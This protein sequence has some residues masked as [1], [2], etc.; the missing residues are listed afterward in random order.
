MRR[1][2]QPSW[3]LVTIDFEASSKAI[4]S[5]PVEI[6]IARWESFTSPIEVW[7]TLIIPCEEWISDGHWSQ[8]SF[9][10]HKIPQETLHKGMTPDQILNK[11]ST[12]IGGAQAI[13]DGG[14]YDSYWMLR[15]AACANADPNFSI[16]YLSEFISRYDDDDR[17]KFFKR[18][19]KDLPP[20]RAG[21]DAVRLL[22]SIAHIYD[23]NP[24]TVSFEM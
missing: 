9:E 20:H 15:L 17:E 14:L 10:I 22:K 7:S 11:S 24:K 18:M 8:E 6:G 12:F 4:K 23:K 19:E 3:P 16:L 21:P 13:C 1:K 5:Y 2:V